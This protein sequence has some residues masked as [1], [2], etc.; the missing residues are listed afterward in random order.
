MQAEHRYRSSHGNTFIQLDYGVRLPDSLMSK[1]RKY[2]IH[3]KTC[4][5]YFKN[6]YVSQLTQHDQ[7]GG[8]PEVRIY[9]L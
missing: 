4:Q 3:A 7:D 6:L 5:N 1:Y 8:L 9:H 2:P